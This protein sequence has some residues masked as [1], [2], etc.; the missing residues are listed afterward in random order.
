MGIA[1]Y[2]KYV[3]KHGSGAEPEVCPVQTEKIR[4][5]KSDGKQLL[6]AAYAAWQTLEQ[7]RGE[8]K[9]NIDY[10]NGNQ[11]ADVVDDPDHKGKKIRE[12]ELLAREGK[13]PLKHNFIQQFIRNLSGQMLNSP[14]Q[15]VVYARTTNDEEL[16]EMLT[17]TLQACHHLNEVARLD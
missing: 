2:F 9:R 12:A 5:K 6:D 1:E 11:W 3:D 17:N 4:S 16:G 15:S 8:R 13:S 14:T 7:L 10:K